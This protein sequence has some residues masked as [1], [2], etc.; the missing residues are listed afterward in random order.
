MTEFKI[1]NRRAT[2][3]L[4]CGGKAGARGTKVT[5]NELTEACDLAKK[6]KK[7]IKICCVLVAYFCMA[8]RLF[9]H[10]G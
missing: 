3:W 6:V 10:H 7:L 5:V 2:Y 1:I 9:L 4:G 8:F